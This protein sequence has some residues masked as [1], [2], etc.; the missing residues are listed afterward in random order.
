MATKLQQSQ[1]KAKAKATPSPVQI[2]GSN[3]VIT[4]PLAWNGT[5]SNK[6]FDAQKDEERTK[7][8]ACI[9]ETMTIN[10]LDYRLGINVTLP[11][12]VKVSAK[13]RAKKELEEVKR[14]NEELKALVR[15]A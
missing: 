12:D 5:F 11:A 7:R 14:E 15:M 13:E 9:Q 8:V 3:I 10:G 1:A 2:V 6:K 4:V